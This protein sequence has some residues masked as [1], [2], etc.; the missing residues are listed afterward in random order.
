MKNNKTHGLTKS[1]FYS[2]WSNMKRRC[3]QTSHNQYQNYGAKGISVCDSWQTF[4]NFMSDMYSSYLEF[5]S[6]HGEDNTSIDRIN[7]NANYQFS[8]CK[9][10]TNIEQARNRNN[11]IIVV[12]NDV[13]Y[14]TL[15]QVAEKFHLSYGLVIGRYNRGKRG[16]E[17]V[18]P[19]HK[20]HRQKTISISTR[21]IKTEVNGVQY[22]SL[23]ALQKDY[24]HISLVS[25]SKRYKKG[26]RG[27]DL[28][29]G[30]KT[31]AISVG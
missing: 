29:Q 26:L 25:I 27:N 18:N 11:N 8:N 2:I 14:K 4:E 23:T 31:R 6:E 13:E 3:E 16:N 28:I 21:G 10:S 22:D 7:S 12:I 24:S 5:V 15:T 20:S 30:Q 9:W 19:I 1:R 17:L